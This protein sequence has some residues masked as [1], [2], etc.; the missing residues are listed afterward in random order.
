MAA[1]IEA[2][3]LTWPPGKKRDPYP[4]ESRFRTQIGKAIKGVQN[5]VERLG[6]RDLVISSNLPLKRDGMPYASQARLS[7]TGVAVYFNYQKKPMCFACDY[8]NTVES[9]MWAIAKTIE[10]LRGIKRWGS[11]DMMQQ[12]F[13]GF[14]ALPA[15]EQPWQVL[16]LDTS[17]PTTEQIEDAY[18]RLAMKHHPDRGGDP[19]EMA[20]INSARDQLMAPS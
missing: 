8:W 4:S 2:F 16:G 5:E 12:A 15:P 14:V 13:T 1:P 20:R 7:D 11:G 18:R 17:R 6:G 10:A 19:N 3:P 9:N